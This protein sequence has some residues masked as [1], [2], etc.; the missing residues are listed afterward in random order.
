MRLR[1]AQRQIAMRLLLIISVVLHLSG[2]TGFLVTPHGR[3]CTG[4]DLSLGGSGREA[5]SMS[6]AFR[7]GC[8]GPT[9]NPKLVGSCC[10]KALLFITQSCPIRNG[11]FPVGTNCAC[12]V[13][14]GMGAA[15]VPGLACDNDD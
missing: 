4:G 8:D 14:N 6:E 9:S 1:N 10:Y 3:K 7:A 13:H 5:G 12:L 11:L 2:C 15:L